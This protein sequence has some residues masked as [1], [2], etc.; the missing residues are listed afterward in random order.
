M[1]SLFVS[2]PPEPT[3]AGAEFAYLVSP[4]GRSAGAYGA[5]PLALLPRAE[6]A[7]AEVVAI[8]P[9]ASLSWHRVELPKGVSPGSPRLRAVLEGLLEDQLLD[10]PDTVHFAVEPQPRAG[11]PVWV[12]VCQRAWLRSALNALEGAGRPVNRIVP[13]ITPASPAALHALGEAG[14]ASLV[15][16]SADGVLNLPLTPG[17]LALVSGLPDEALCFAEPAVAAE[18]ENVLQRAVVLQPAAQRWLLAGQSRWDLAQFEFAS[19]GR[20]RQVKRFNAAWAELLRAP[21]WRPARWAAVALVAVNLLG[22][23]AW[24]W[25][26]RSSLA[27]KREAVRGTLT[28]AFPNVRVVVDAPTQMER[29]VA[30]LRQAA[31]VTSSRDL[32]ALLGALATAAPNRNVTGLEYSAGELRA[33][34]LN[35]SADELRAAQTTLRSQGV[36]ASQQGDAVLLRAEATQ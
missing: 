15:A 10:E 25:K 2:L 13:E 23:N 27:D 33:R 28:R 11:A 12:A 24:A 1:S 29:E 35:W 3:A 34:G 6:G 36:T 20:A 9:S 32:E 21:Q 22:L 17:A 5:A 7:G 4:D 14:N 16:S 30:T 31:G 26:E 18:A 19:S 8:M